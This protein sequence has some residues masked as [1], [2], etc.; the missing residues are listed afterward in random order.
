MPYTQES[1]DVNHKGEIVKLYTELTGSDS[2]E[3]IKT[4][5]KAIIREPSG[6]LTSVKMKDVYYHT[7]NPGDV[8]AWSET[9]EKRPVLGLFNFMFLTFVGM[10]VFIGFLAKISN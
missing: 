5:Y 9:F 7:A 8:F 4:V 3:E 10:G 2:S 1:Y 6:K